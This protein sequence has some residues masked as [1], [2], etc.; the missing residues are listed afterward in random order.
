M[1]AASRLLDARARYVRLATRTANHGQPRGLAAQRTILERLDAFAELT[2]A[3]DEYERLQ[4]ISFVGQRY[5]S[6]L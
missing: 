3:H 1:S 4:K 5:R 2:R 6:L